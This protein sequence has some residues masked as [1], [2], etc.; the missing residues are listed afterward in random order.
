M[1][2]K[3][4]GL[5]EGD[6]PGTRVEVMQVG[7]PGETPTLELRMQIDG[8]DMG[9][10]TLKR[11]RMASGQIG[12]LRDALNLMDPDAQQAKTTRRPTDAPAL[13]LIG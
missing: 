10:M 6:E 13:R 1:F 3:S 12:Q 11:I 2:E 7:A 8:G 5:L 9:W 4:L